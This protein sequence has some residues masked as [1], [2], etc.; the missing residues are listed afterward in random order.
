MYQS[1]TIED[2]LRQGDLFL[3]LPWLLFDPTKTASRSGPLNIADA[4]LTEST[5]SVAEKSD[6]RVNR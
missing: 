3:D 4:G 2:E 6:F 5:R 1:L